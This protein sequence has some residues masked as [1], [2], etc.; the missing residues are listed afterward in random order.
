MKLLAT[1]T[2]VSALAFAAPAH[3][4]LLNSGNS[5]LLGIGNNLLAFQTGHI[6]VLNGGVLNGSNVLSGIGLGSSASA[7]N[8]A[9]NTTGSSHAVVTGRDN[10]YIPGRGNTIVSGK[11]NTVGSGNI[12]GYGHTVVPGNSNVIGTGNAVGNQWGSN[13]Y[14]HSL[15][16]FGW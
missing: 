16:S 8:A 13:F 1:A 6:S 7:N 11:G 10:T 3:A 15:N 5:G 2:V 4:Q 14:T 12:S 9:T